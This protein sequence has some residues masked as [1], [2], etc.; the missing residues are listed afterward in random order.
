MTPPTS[1]ELAYTAVAWADL[2]GH[3]WLRVSGR[4]RLDFLQRLSTND[5]RKLT[6]CAGLPTVLATATGR[7]IALLIACASEDAVYLH[8]A[9]GRA[10]TLAS[11]LSSLIFWN[12]ELEVSD[13]SVETVQFGLFG[14]GAV[15]WLA[16]AAGVVLDDLQPYAWC[17]GSIGGTPVMIQRGGAL[18]AP[19]W[20]IIAAAKYMDELRAILTA[21]A[22]ALNEGQA[23]VRRV[24]KGIPAWGSELSDQVTPLEAG[25]RDAL[26]DNKGCYT[27]QEVIARQLNYDKVTRR[28]VGLL[29]PADAPIAELRGATIAAGGS[30]HSRGGFVGTAVWSPVLERPIALAFVPRDLA[31]PGAKVMIRPGER[32]II[33]TVTAL[34]FVGQ[35]SQQINKSAKGRIGE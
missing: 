7:M 11:H 3:G 18:E 28:M 4:D 26:S 19:D 10:G 35:E 6:P 8:T 2:S 30:G 33:A 16:D 21:T 25:L 12:D 5:F 32:E 15:K 29:L 23:E 1:P 14:P 34:P 31:E 27:G 20:T 22:S 13:L 17:S 9:P 24:E